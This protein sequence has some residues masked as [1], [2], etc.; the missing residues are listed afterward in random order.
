MLGRHCAVICLSYCVDEESWCIRY[1]RSLKCQTFPFPFSL[2]LSLSL[3]HSHSHSHT[4]PSALVSLKNERRM[5]GGQGKVQRRRAIGKSPPLVPH[6]IVDLSTLY[7]QPQYPSYCL[8]YS[9]YL[10]YEIG[11]VP[12]SNATPRYSTVPYSLI[13]G[14]LLHVVWT[15]RMARFPH[16]V[17][18]WHLL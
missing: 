12:H 7:L 6:S 9:L 1:L 2:F 15:H 13:Q 8:S 3:A 11:D 16:P 18:A 17:L 10:A 14:T 4:L 5:G